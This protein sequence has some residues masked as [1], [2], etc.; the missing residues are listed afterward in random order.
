MEKVKERI[1]KYDNLRGLAIFL[2]VFG[3]LNL[4]GVLNPINHVVYM[5]DLP[6]LFFVAGYFSKIDSEQ[7]IKSFK[8]LMVPYFIFCLLIELFRWACTGTLKW[9]MIFLQASM[10]MWFLIAL[11]IM[12]MILPIMDRLRYPIITTLLFALLFGLYDIHPN[13]LGLTRTF[14]YLPIFLLGFYFNRYRENFSIQHPKLF[15]FCDRNFKLLMVILI[16]VSGICLFKISGKFFLFK[17]P[18]AGRLEFEAIKRLIVLVLEMFWV[19]ALNRIMTNRNCFLTK[20]GRNSMAVYLLHLFVFSYL[21]PVW[22][23]LVTGNLMA[24]ILSLALTAIC[25]FVFSRDVVTKYLNKFTDCVFDLL[26]KPV[27]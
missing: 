7:P 4:S 23:S 6:L 11:F 16:I 25:V 9:D 10:G 19:V 26:V 20:I 12:K 21:K 3:H 13:I 24:A 8:R 22:P 18:Y 2:V 27:A 5:I 15:G 14:A 17:E 1:N